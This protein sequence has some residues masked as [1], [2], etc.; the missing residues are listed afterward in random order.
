MAKILVVDDQPPI[1]R[2][3]ELALRAAGHEVL[4][5]QSKEEGMEVACAAKPDLM[6]VDVM[7]PTGTE[8]FHLVWRVRQLEDA[9]LRDLPIIIASGIH[10][11]TELRFYPD[12]TDGTYQPGEFL[13]VQG[14]IDKP[15]NVAD[16]TTK[17][18]ALLK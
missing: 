5:A 17:I 11:E 12:K 6:V 3:L 8:G 1:L 16:L 9:R 4:V 14:W 2:T 10:G 7:M 18:E 15:V 13:P